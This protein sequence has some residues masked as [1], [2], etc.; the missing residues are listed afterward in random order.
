MKWKV[1]VVKNAVLL[2][3]IACKEGT[4]L[5]LDKSLGFGC[6]T[7]SNSHPRIHHSPLA[8]TLVYYGKSGRGGRVGREGK[9]SIGACP[10]PCRYPSAKCSIYPYPC[11]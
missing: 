11:L 8:H 5:N 10:C 4:F 3:V 7:R 2:C 1:Q 6:T 9:E